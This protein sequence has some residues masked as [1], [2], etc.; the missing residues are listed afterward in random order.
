MPC[1]R[2]VRSRAT[3]ASIWSGHVVA[4]RA[5]FLAESEYSDPVEVRVGHERLDLTSMHV[6]LAGE[7]H[8]EVE[9]IP[10][11]GSAVRM[12][13]TIDSKRSRPPHLPIP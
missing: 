2:S 8:D 1:T 13:P 5:L 9:R 4:P 7:T 3:D 10:A 12:R 6:L 11:S